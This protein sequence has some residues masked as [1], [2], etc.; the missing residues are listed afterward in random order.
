MN[1]TGMY[2]KET[3]DLSGKDEIKSV[4]I[5]ENAADLDIYDFTDK[6]IVPMLRS[7]GYRDKTI[8]KVINI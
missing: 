5:T 7:I 6:F 1:E 8:N 3:S 2:Y 4:C